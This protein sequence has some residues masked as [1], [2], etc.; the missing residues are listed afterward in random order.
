M[1]AHGGIGSV[2]NYKQNDLKPVIAEGWRLSCLYGHIETAAHALVMQ[3]QQQQQQALHSV[4]VHL[5]ALALQ[6]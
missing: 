1:A 6:S 5:A 4:R 2:S 3:Q